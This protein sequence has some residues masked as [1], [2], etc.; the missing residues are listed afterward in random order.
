M[1]LLLIEDL[2]TFNT[3]RCDGQYI[4]SRPSFP[5]FL[6]GLNLWLWISGISRSGTCVG[7]QRDCPL[8]YWSRDLVVLSRMYF[9]VLRTSWDILCVM[10]QFLMHSVRVLN[11]SLGLPDRGTTVRFPVIC[12]KFCNRHQIELCLLIFVCFALCDRWKGQKKEKA[13][14]Y[15]GGSLSLK[16]VCN[17]S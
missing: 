14:L 12:F 16:C 9:G 11:P 5:I 17:D 10:C 1:G 2:Y 8:L 13:Q 6:E 7:S 3:Q 4:P 15:T